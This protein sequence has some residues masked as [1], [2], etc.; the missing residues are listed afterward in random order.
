[1]LKA[2]AIVATGVVAVATILL[3]LAVFGLDIHLHWPF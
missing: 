2:I 3:I 1:M